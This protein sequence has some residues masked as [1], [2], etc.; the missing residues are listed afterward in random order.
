M[1]LGKSKCKLDIENWPTRTVCA[2]TINFALCYSFVYAINHLIL[3]N[4]RMIQVNGNNWN[5]ITIFP[6]KPCIG[7]NF[8]WKI[9][10]AFPKAQNTAPNVT[11]RPRTSASL[12]HEVCTNGRVWFKLFFFLNSTK[13]WAR[14]LSAELLICRTVA[15]EFNSTLSASYLGLL[16]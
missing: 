10:Y 8:K 15:W 6:L 13:N 1:K 9:I 16:S 2:T 14:S 3:F 7:F 12:N 11:F 5:I 4:C